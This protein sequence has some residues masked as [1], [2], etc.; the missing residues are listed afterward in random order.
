LTPGLPY[1]ISSIPTSILDSCCEGTLLHLLHCPLMP[2]LQS[3]Y[4]CHQVAPC[5]SPDLIP[6]HKRTM[7]AK[8]FL[9]PSLRDTLSNV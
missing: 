3:P 9:S 8:F 1:G 7:Q 4:C 5:N 6:L 2:S